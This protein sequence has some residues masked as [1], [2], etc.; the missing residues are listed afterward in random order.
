MIRFLV[1]GRGNELVSPAEVRGTL[2]QVFLIWE[3]SIEG[4]ADTSVYMYCKLTFIDSKYIL[5]H[6]ALDVFS[7]F[8][9]YVY[10]LR[11]YIY[12]SIKIQVL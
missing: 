7:Y 5:A 8:M 10:I 3:S 9:Y 12:L 4:K 1:L 11:L 2:Q 6:F